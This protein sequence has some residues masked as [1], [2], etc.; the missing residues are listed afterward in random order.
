MSEGKTVERLTAR[1]E[2]F[3]HEYLLDGCGSRAAIR[4]GYAANRAE[5]TASRLLT[6]GKVAARLEVL[7]S[8][9]LERVD[10]SAD[11]LLRELVTLSTITMDAFIDDDGFLVGNLKDIPKE[12][13]AVIH[14]VSQESTTDPD[15]NT[16]LKIRLKLHDRVKSLALLGK[17]VS[18][19][20]FS[21]RVEVAV[22]PLSER[23][24]EIAR[25]MALEDAR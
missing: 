22:H 8:R 15:G 3:I 10:F 6:I 18:V 19:R 25:Q 14:E 11:D 4:A 16:V 12:A 5:V 20:A 2:R 23:M 1:Q 17:H 21:E 13:R 24:A 7:T 9:Q